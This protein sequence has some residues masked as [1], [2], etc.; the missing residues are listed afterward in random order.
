MTTRLRSLPVSILLLVG[1]PVTLILLAVALGGAALHTHAMHEMVAL[2]DERSVRAAAAGLALRLGGETDPQGALSMAG[3]WLLAEESPADGALLFLISADGRVLAHPDPARLGEAVTDYPGV[4]AVLEG[5][6]GSTVGV[7]PG[8]GEEIIIAYSPI[9]GTGWALILEES[10]GRI[11]GPRVQY[12]QLAPLVLLPALILAAV[13][14]YV[15]IRQIVQPLQ[16]LDEQATRLGWGEFDAVQQPV[17][18]IEEIR[19][20]QTTLSRMARQL[21][22]AQAGMRSYAAA[23]LRGQEEERARL[24]R[25]LHDETVQTLIALEHRI[26]G[27][28]RALSRDPLTVEGRLEELAQMATDSV[29]EVRRVVRALRPL[30]LE[31]L[32]WVSAVRALAE[33]LDKRGS[34]TATFSLQ[35]S[36]RRLHPVQELA[37]YRIAQEALN[38]VEHHSQA[39]RVDVQVTVAREIR[40]VIADNGIGFRLP[41]RPEGLAAAGHFGLVGMTERAQI[42]GGRLSLQSAPGAGTCV[43]IVIPAGEQP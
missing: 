31:D 6:T 5:R 36:E 17:G 35:G 34:M 10:W 33:E 13:T 38:N 4:A 16:Q 20:L 39:D 24:A 8:T 21:A 41:D 18:G 42:I 28:R 14:I 9:E 1:L 29:H 26:H 43:E 12:T 11:A 25:E 23:L 32:G 15:G 30:Y 2:R 3:E 19:A 37:L 40:L 22:M 27:V 7:R